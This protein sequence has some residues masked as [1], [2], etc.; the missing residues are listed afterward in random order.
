M[1]QHS[2]Q[3]NV[4]IRGGFSS[5]VR[6]FT[7][8]NSLKRK[9][10]CL[11]AA[12]HELSTCNHLFSRESAAFTKFLTRNI[13]PT[14]LIRTLVYE[15]SRRVSARDRNQGSVW[16]GMQGEMSGSSWVS[17]HLARTEGNRATRPLLWHYDVRVRYAFFWRFTHQTSPSFT[18]SRRLEPTT[19]STSPCR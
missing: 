6:S 1:R 7:V 5:T 19:L 12:N 4:S 16:F 3:R 2:A 8:L 17:R 15:K 18:R 14:R 13:W 11:A 10:E 9:K